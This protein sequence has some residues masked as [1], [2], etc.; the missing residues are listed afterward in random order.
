MAFTNLINLVTNLVLI[1]YVKITR[2]L[3]ESVKILGSLSIIV[4]NFFFFLWFSLL[5]GVCYQHGLPR[6]VLTD[7]V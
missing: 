2:P 6:L 1:D 5:V 7:P 3:S 4:S